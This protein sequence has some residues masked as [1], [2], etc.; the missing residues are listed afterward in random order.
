MK[1]SSEIIVKCIMLWAMGLSLRQICDYMESLEGMFVSH[2]SVHRWLRKYIKLLKPHLDSIPVNCQDMH[3]HADEK[4]LH[5]KGRTAYE[6]IVKCKENKFILA[7]RITATRRGVEAKAA[8]AEA[9]SKIIGMPMSITTDDYAGY[10]GAFND[11]F[12]SN[13]YPRV[14]HHHSAGVRGL[15]SNNLIER[16][17]S[18]L[19][20]RLYTVRGFKE[21]GSTGNLMNMVN[22]VYFNHLRPNLALGGKTPAEAAGMEKKSLIGMIEDAYEWQRR[23]YN[24]N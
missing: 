11:S 17:N 1:F 12:Y 4:M 14:E 5:V 10:P 23:T 21:L 13:R 19:Q 7:D 22:V 15:I 24:G 16:H 3:L 2:A 8:F 9:K 20:G 6:W 18:M